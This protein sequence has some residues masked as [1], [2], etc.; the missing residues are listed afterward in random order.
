MTDKPHLWYPVKLPLLFLHPDD[1]FTL[2]RLP[3]PSITQ[4]LSLMAFCVVNTKLCFQPQ[5]ER[6]SASGQRISHWS[7]RPNIVCLRVSRKMLPLLWTRHWERVL[8]LCPCL[9]STT[10]SP[11]SI[12]Y[13]HHSI[14][15]KYAFPPLSLS[16]PIPSP[17]WQT[18]EHLLPL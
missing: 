18:R 6:K 13:L 1:T 15:L 3:T 11:S 5:R 12:E 16:P 8:L 7:W 4:P 17:T 10:L 2:K 9:L 14:A